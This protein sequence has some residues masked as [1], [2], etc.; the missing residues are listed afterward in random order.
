MIT[1]E[2][3]NQ[4][5]IY[6]RNQLLYKS[7]AGINNRNIFQKSKCNYKKMFFSNQ[8]MNPAV[9]VGVALP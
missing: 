2:K 3:K 9:E 7:L 1:F 6:V 5:N 8:S 4:G